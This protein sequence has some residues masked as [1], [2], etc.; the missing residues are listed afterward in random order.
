MSRLLV[1][2]VAQVADDVRREV[3]EVDGVQVSALV[4]AVEHPRATIVALHGGSSN[5]AY[6]HDSWQPRRSL[7]ALGVA[8]GF[9]VVS[10]ERP[11]YGAS[12]EQGA[13]LDGRGTVELT[14]GAL[15]RLVPAGSRGAGF[16]VAAHS[17]GCLLAL[18]MAVADRGAQLLGLELAGTGLRMGEQAE[19]LDKQYSAR[20]LRDI[21]WGPA[22][23]Y[24]PGNGTPPP[25]SPSPAYERADW[26]GWFDE[27]PALAAAVRV[28]IRYV[29]GDHEGWWR[30]TRSDVDDVAGCFTASPRVITEVQHRGGHNLS[31]GLSATAYHLKL[32]AFV[33]ECLLD[34]DARTGGSAE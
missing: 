28:P 14:Y 2:R 32:L 6:F 19:A 11:G 33:E 15:D 20:A 3:V 29:L 4:R 27:F 34:A 12:A 22:E 25:S 1:P 10:L 24:P 17:M 26:S 7:L 13:T 16:F 5:A 21:I 18:R 23:L 9:T 31:R 8:L 30:P